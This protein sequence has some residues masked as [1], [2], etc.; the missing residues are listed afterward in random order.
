MGDIKICTNCKIEK[1]ID[2]FYA[3]KKNGKI[4]YRNIC[5]KCFD[6][7][8]SERKFSK[9]KIEKYKIERDYTDM[10]SDDD[11]LKLES[12]LIHYN[13]IMDIV[14][15]TVNLWDIEDVKANRI[16][17]SIKMNPELDKIILAY[18]RK[19]R[20]SYSDVC[21]IALREGLKT[22]KVEK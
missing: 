17:K 21:N 4:Y 7:S 5:K 12:L 20:L 14:N 15:K 2:K 18:A 10:L 22:L 19:S 3:L 1:D 13:S 9:E 8:R 16:H 11:K 6:K